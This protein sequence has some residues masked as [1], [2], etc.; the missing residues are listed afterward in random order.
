[1]DEV[2]VFSVALAEEDIKDI[3]NRGLVAATGVLAVSS[4]GK[5]TSIWG[6]IKGKH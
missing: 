2:A 3:V 6:G 1:M 5:L 4:A